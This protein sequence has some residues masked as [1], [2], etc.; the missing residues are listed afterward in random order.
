MLKILFVRGPAATHM[1]AES[2]FIDGLRKLGEYTDLPV[3]ADISPEELA[4]II[5]QYDVL[6]TMWDNI[7]IPAELAEDSGRLKYVCNITGSLK[8]WIPAEIILSDKIIVTNWGDLPANCVAEGAFTLILAMLKSLPAYV[9]NIRS[10]GWTPPFLHKSG[11]LKGLRLGMY[12]M[13]AIGRRF[14]ELCKPFQPVIYVYDPYIRE[15]PEGCIRVDSLENLFDVS[16]AVAVHAALSA[17]TYK[18]ITAEL[19]ARLPDDAIIVNTARG[20]VFDQQALFAELEP[21]RLRAGLDVLDEDEFHDTLVPDHPARQWENCLFT[22]HSISLD[23]WGKTEHSYAAMY[24]RA[25]ENITRFANKQPVNYIMDFER[26]Q[27]ST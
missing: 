9:M 3:S 23:G 4:A 21:G 24:D 16:Q 1:L 15:L 7:A 2:P 14:V 10:G 5:R 20:G 22:A 19:L 8:P 13:G 17:E 26:Y 6:L 11:S 12:G 27:K 18:S 25:L